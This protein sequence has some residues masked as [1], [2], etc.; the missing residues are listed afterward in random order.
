MLM[1]N[2]RS[3]AAKK[4]AL[5]YDGVHQKAAPVLQDDKWKVGRLIHFLEL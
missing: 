3:P 4:D 2:K 5:L 1:K